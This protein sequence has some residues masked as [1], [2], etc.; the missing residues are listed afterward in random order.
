M[1][2]GRKT[3]QKQEEDTG[4]RGPVHHVRTADSQRRRNMK[5]INKILVNNDLVA[6]FFDYVIP[7]KLCRCV[8]TQYYSDTGVENVCMLWKNYVHKQ[9]YERFG[10]R[11]EE[12]NEGYW[13]C[14][15]CTDIV[16]NFEKHGRKLLRIADMELSENN[17]N[18]A[19]AIL[20][21]DKYRW[22]TCE[23]HD[24]ILM[25]QGQSYKHVVPVW[26]KASSFKAPQYY[27]SGFQIPFQQSS[28]ILNQNLHTQNVMSLNQNFQ[29]GKSISQFP[30]PTENVQLN[31]SLQKLNFGENPNVEQDQ[32]P[33]TYRPEH[34]RLVS[35][36]DENA[37]INPIEGSYFADE[38]NLLKDLGEDMHFPEASDI[39][40]P[41]LIDEE[42]KNEASQALSFRSN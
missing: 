12:N 17:K 13:L 31:E 6:Q 8:G 16:Q 29:P 36:L 34:Y 33:R 14:N 32:N 24:G 22:T 9:W 21:L 19:K 26:V 38:G 20:N 1:K 28:N 11:D 5:Q 7:N 42:D 10:A 18:I 30:R 4:P 27:G 37:S 23:K 41:E 15:K 35:D 3:K 2:R 39:Q 40:N 25:K